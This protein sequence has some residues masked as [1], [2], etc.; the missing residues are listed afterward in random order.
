MCTAWKRL[1]AV[2]L[3]ILLG[4][5][6]GVA[7][8]FR[9]GAAQVDIT[10]LQFP[11]RV[12][13]MVEERTADRAADALM[14][15]ALVLDDGSVQLAIVV[16]DSLML[17]REMLDDVKQQ[18]AKL[19]GIPEDRML[20]SATHTHSA[21]SAMACLGSRVDPEY[22]QFLPAQIVRSIVQAQE[23]LEPAEAGWAVVT[24][25]LHNHCRRWIFRSDR[26]SMTDP[27][28]VRN[29]RAHMHPGYQSANHTGPAGPADTDLTLLGLRSLDGRPLAVLANYAMHY[30]GSPLV[31]ADCCGRFGQRFAELL[32]ASGQSRAFVGL[33]S[34]GTSGDSMWM[35]YSR[36]AVANDLD[37]Y[38]TGLA[39]KALE[40]W[41]LIQWRKD[42]S[43]AMAE[44]RL[45][46]QR[47]VPDE[48]RLEWARKLSAEVG[49][50]LPR[51]WSEVYSFEQLFLHEEP[52]RELKLQAIRIGE[53]GITAIPDEVFG[54]TGL[55][56]KQASPLAVTMNIELANG[57][58]GYIPPPEQHVL[59]GYTTWPARTAA[60]EV[61]AE[62][63]IV[64]V[65]TKLL[66]RVS[67]Q[68]A[69]ALTDEQHAY[70]QA[71]SQSL[72]WAYW[73][74]GE[75]QGQPV[76]DQLEDGWRVQDQ[77]AATGQGRQAIYEP[78][79]AFF[80]PGPRGAGLQQQFRGNRAV[81]F[82]GGRVR[83]GRQG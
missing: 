41:R 35:D 49:D 48:G 63:Q 5:A 36:P 60:L 65:L 67:G 11:V 69:N 52:E 14:S 8:Q 37:G 59:G 80:L 2:L 54:I 17:P 79:V 74:L 44:E 61:Q 72:P 24:D 73:R 76:S 31:S 21:P 43:L 19:T 13:G 16:V 23:R 83:A 7:A 27:F 46:L 28:G 4:P 82:A 20:I 55:K 12:N 81:Q 78:G 34:Q 64:G 32:G 25:D 33:L 6:V 53:L 38:V 71:V 18:A 68:V 77:V 51:G 40:A 57:A 45:R 56:L 42:V 66:E 10:P 26:M 39:T 50:R 70:A 58:E 22:A 75:L 62:P 29:V 3:L 47:R 30:Y 1:W 15:R 9:A